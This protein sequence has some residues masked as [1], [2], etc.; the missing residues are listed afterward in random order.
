MKQM[1]EFSRRE[2]ASDAARGRL[3]DGL[4]GV[5]LSALLNDA[6]SSTSCLQ[7]RAGS[8]N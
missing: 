8:M 7:V 6:R 2:R 3:D 4:K 1:L 5:T